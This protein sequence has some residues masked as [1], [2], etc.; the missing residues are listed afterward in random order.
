[1]M[2]QYYLDDNLRLN[3][4]FDKISQMIE[5]LNSEEKQGK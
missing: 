2:N 4:L 3:E 1:M 5:E